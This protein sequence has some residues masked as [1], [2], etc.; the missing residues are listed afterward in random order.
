MHCLE[1]QAQGEKSHTIGVC[2]TCRA[3]VGAQHVRPVTRSVR[4]GSFIGT[5][6][7]HKEHTLLCPGCAE[8]HAPAVAAH[9]R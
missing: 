4:H 6:G 5:P 7:G 1:C 3:A 9:T 8:V 2:H